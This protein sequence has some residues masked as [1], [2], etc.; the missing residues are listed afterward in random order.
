MEIYMR[1]CD[2]TIRGRRRAPLRSRPHRGHA[3]V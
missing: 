3:T 2:A 1:A